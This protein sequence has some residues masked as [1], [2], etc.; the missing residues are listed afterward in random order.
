[1]H[2]NKRIALEPCCSRTTFFFFDRKRQRNILIK[3]MYKRR[4]R[5]PP[6]KEKQNYKESNI[7]KYKVKTSKLSR[8]DQ[9]I[10]IIHR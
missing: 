10:G 3:R 8:L 2:G 4:M 6:I 5:N 7:R 1:M 9:P